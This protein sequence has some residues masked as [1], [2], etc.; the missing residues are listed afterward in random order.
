[1]RLWKLQQE[2]RVL[3]QSLASIRSQIELIETVR[4]YE[5]RIT[6]SP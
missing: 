2:Q 3:Q 6:H 1:L 4:R 5:L